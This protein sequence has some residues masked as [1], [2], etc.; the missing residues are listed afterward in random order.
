M[1]SKRLVFTLIPTEPEIEL[2]EKIFYDSLE[3]AVND[4]W[5][6]L[7][8]EEVVEALMENNFP[9]QVFHVSQDIFIYEDPSKCNIS[10]EIPNEVL[11]SL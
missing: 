10:E 1:L 7:S 2:R 9:F 8:D 3:D 5:D 4:G 6:N 11:I